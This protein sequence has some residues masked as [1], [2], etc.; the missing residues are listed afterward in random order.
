MFN[1]IKLLLRVHTHRRIDGH[2][3]GG[4]CH[5]ALLT[6]F[7][8][9]KLL[10]LLLL[11]LMMAPSWAFGLDRPW[12]LWCPVRIGLPE[13]KHRC[14]L[15]GRRLRFCMVVVKPELRCI[16]VD[17][18]A[19]ALQRSHWHMSSQRSIGIVNSVVTDLVVSCCHTRFD[20]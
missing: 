7:L 17:R 2:L 10:L 19:D 4:L 16:R 13:R 9:V 18:L 14:V 20:V 3:F 11:L 12:S 5:G 1:N 8:L 6:L 15:L